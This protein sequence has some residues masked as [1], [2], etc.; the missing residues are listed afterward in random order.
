MIFISPLVSRCNSSNTSS[1]ASSGDSSSASKTPRSTKSG[2]SVTYTGRG[3]PMTAR[4][5]ALADAEGR[6]VHHCPHCE[7]TTWRSG[8]YRIHMRRHSGEKPFTC[9]FKGCDYASSQHSN[10][11]I[12][13]RIHNGDKPFTC[14]YE[15][16]DFAS[17]QQSNL[18]AHIQ[19]IHGI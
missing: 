8:N 16:C 14:E 17:V 6:K 9:D 15:G 13:R 10:L 12:H 3:R 4:E 18:K 5:H 7:Y 1:S 2:K 11:K 19:R